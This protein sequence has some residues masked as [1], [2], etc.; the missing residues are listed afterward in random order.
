MC[1]IAGVWS[2]DPLLDVEAA[3]TRMLAPLKRRGPDSSGLWVDVE[4][5]M[6]LVHARLSVID[7]SDL[8]SQPMRSRS[9]RFVIVFNGEIYNFRVLRKELE[10]LGY[11]FRSASDTEVAL[12][13]FEHW[14]P[15][16]APRHFVGMFAIGLWDVT[17]RRLHLI[18]DRLGKKPLSFLAGPQIVAFSSLVESFEK[19]PDLPLKIDYSSVSTFLSHGYVPANTCIY[20]GIEKVP[21]GCVVTIDSHGERSS[22]PFWRLPPD[23]VTSDA[24]RSLPFSEVVDR[25]HDLARRAVADRLLADVPIGLFL[26]SGIDSA[27]VAA[28]MQAESTAPIRTFTVGFSERQYDEAPLAKRI[29][30]HLGGH[31]ET[32]YISEADAQSAATVVHESFDEP[33][34][35]PSAIPVLLLARSVRSNVTV[36]LTGD[37]GDEVFGGYNRHSF[38]RRMWPLVAAIPAPLRGVLSQFL[39]ALPATRLEAML[40]GRLKSVVPSMLGMKI[41]KAAGFIRQPDLAHA[42]REML[43]TWPEAARCIVPRGTLKGDPVNWQAVKDV[44]SMMAADL[45]GYMVDDVLVKVDRATMSVGLE[46][47]SPLLD[48]RVVELG[49]SLGLEAH[50]SG[51]RSKA[52]LRAIAGR[53]IP[54]N[55][56]DRPKA[57]FAPPL[58]DWLRGPLRE[59][60]ESL[61][62][63]ENLAHAGFVE[64]S[65]VIGMWKDH[66]KGRSSSHYPIWNVLCLHAWARARAKGIGA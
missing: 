25:V 59:W 12:A 44:R 16:E 49:M 7:L 17:E 54:G 34:A 18:R 41:G 58:E 11:S 26:S 31:H 62:S 14:G 6:G 5:R 21:P 24:A 13:A 56:L 3:A 64:P 22:S 29:S 61:L 40:G 36:A 35:D 65:P 33:F 30:S 38:A 4:A 63:R 66:L 15:L 50:F 19:L 53:Y 46:A 39:Q 52:I 9:G 43:Q 23:V 47:R 10:T 20:E 1:G 28:L 60:A 45:T 51:G 8:G 48:H 57:G 42:Y 55:L 32:L 27:V 2:A 37:G